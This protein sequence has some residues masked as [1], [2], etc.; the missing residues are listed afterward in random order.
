MRVEYLDE[1]IADFTAE[2]GE[3]PQR[4]EFHLDDYL[5]LLSSVKWGSIDSYNGIPIEIYV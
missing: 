1:V 3:E 5:D 4:L 2:Y